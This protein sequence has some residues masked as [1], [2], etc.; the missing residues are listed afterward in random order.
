MRPRTPAEP[1]E[2]P[3]KRLTLSEIVQQLLARGASD[4]SFV[5]LTRNAKGETQVDVKVGV[6]EGSEVGTLAEAEAQARAI[7]DRLS[8]AYD[9]TEAA[10][11]GT[12]ELSRNAKGETQVE[13][14]LRTGETGPEP[15]TLEE[16][17]ARAA[18]TYGRLRRRFPMTDGHTGGGGEQPA[19]EGQA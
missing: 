17:A 13:V 8:A 9:V 1:A 16:A 11:Q 15:H 19:A 14:Q 7:Y 2:A 12:V 6:S 10:E 4:R 3:A 5:Q 18:D